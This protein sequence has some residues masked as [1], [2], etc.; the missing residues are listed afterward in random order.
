M[1][2]RDHWN[3]AVLLQPRDRLDW[4]VMRRA[5]AAVIDHHDAL[6]LRFEARHGGWHAEHG[7]APAAD[8]LLWVR[9]A[10]DRDSVTALASSAQ[11]SLSISGGLLLRAVGIDVA[12]GS[13]RF[14]IVIHHLV[15]DGVSWRI[16]FEDIASAYTQLAQGDATGRASAEEPRVRAVGTALAGIRN[17]A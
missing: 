5:L 4:D 12:D 8:A 17:V 10:I 14:V 1:E 13:Q 9:Q 2:N 15:V 6:R 16:L 7:A 11:A 3:Q